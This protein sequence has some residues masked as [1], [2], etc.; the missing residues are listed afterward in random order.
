[1]CF[2][3]NFSKFLRTPLFTEHLWTAASCVPNDFLIAKLGA[4]GFGDS[5]F[6]LIYS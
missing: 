3:A 6:L 1:M 2:P 4:Y 5:S